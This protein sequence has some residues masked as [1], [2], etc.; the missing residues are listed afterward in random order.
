MNWKKFKDWVE[1]Q[2]V[3]D[4]MDIEDIDIRYA[5]YVE[6]LNIDMNIKSFVIY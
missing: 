2:G 5:T 6:E 1:N 4:D 3:T